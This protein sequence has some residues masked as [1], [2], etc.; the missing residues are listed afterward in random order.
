MSFTYL[1]IKMQHT[2][3]DRLD[4][5]KHTYEIKG[6]NVMQSKGRSFRYNMTLQYI[7]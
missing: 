2:N 5:N 1:L 6:E 3:L 4:R 7:I